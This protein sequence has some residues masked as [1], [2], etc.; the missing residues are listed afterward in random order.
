MAAVYINLIGIG[1]RGRRCHRGIDFQC[2][3]LDGYSG[4]EAYRSCPRWRVG[5]GGGIRQRKEK[6]DN[7]TRKRNIKFTVFFWS[8]PHASVPKSNLSRRLTLFSYF[9]S[10]C[11]FLDEPERR[12]KGRWGFDFSP[13]LSPVGR[14]L[15]IIYH[16]S[17]PFHFVEIGSIV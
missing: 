7:P 13:S 16:V 11:I 8:V 6:R 4:V 1:C 9:L 2:G 14:F 15:L 17:F 12:E 5:S 10:V 3:Q